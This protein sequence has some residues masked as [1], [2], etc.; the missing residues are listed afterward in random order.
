MIQGDKFTR[1]ILIILVNLEICNKGYTLVN[2][3]TTSTVSE[4]IDFFQKLREFIN[5][6]SL[7]KSRLIIGGD[8]NCV[9]NTS[10]RT[11]G[12]IDKSTSALTVVLDNFDLVDVWK[13]LNPGLVQ[14]TYID[15]SPR[16]CNSRIDLLL[17]SKCL[18]SMCCSSKTDYAPVPDHKVVSVHLKAKVNDRGKG[19]WQINNNLLKSKEY[20]V[21]ITEL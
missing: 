2:M 16:M 15:S 20:E 1:I 11:S 5:L 12:I 19:Y 8:F 18:E 10:D 13:Y 14:F 6:H 4:R 3:Y 7:N 17:F 21:G 9:L